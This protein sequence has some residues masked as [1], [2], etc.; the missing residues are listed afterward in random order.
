[1]KTPP[2]KNRDS[3][4]RT[5]TAACFS[6]QA[7][8]VGTY[9]SYGVFFNPLMETFDWSRAA[10]SG[11]SSAA[12]F[13]TG[14]FG[15]L[16]G[17]LNDRIGPRLLMSVA[18]FFMGLGFA[19]MSQVATLL[20]LYLVF[21][22]VFGIG[23]SAVDVIAL[24]TIAR[25]FALNRGKMTGIVKVGTGAGQFFI[26][27]LASVLIAA[28]GYQTAFII[29]GFIAFALLMI[30]A[31]FL[32]RDPDI[33]DAGQ[34]APAVPFSVVSDA[35]IRPVQTAGIDYSLAL[36]SPKLWLLCLSNLLLVFCLMSIM[37]HIVP[38]ARDMGI[39]PHRAAGILAT[40]GAVSMAGR[41]AGGLL[42]DRTGSKRIMILSFV[43]LILSLFWL[44]RADTLWELYAFA[45]IYGI[46]HGGFFTAI[47]P[48][49]A[50]LFGIRSHGGLF[51][52]VVFF[53]TT[54]GALGP[55]VTGLLFD[56]FLNYTFAFSSLILIAAV[57][58][59][60]MIGV[61]T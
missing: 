14:I 18:A 32:Y 6:I 60:L 7:V 28:A 16:V 54:G 2:R 4:S 3:Y 52:I 53:G 55:F 21:G 36:K 57:A 25:W 61:R 24:S 35:V 45:F 34:T 15:M 37:L 46:A 1:M 20:Q 17:R 9:I 48:M 39:P 33:Y 43:L 22:L 44:T 11:A 38:Y 29:L 19:L 59:V 8:G 26:P 40:I 41:F 10:I 51:G 13:I 12:F 23:L 58:F 27:I 49:V 50:E 42:I 47:S 31:Q 5:I 30:I 56:R